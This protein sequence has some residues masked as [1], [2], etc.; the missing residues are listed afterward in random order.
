MVI[1]QIGGNEMKIREIR[2]RK[3]ISRY[4]LAQISDVQDPMSDRRRIECIVR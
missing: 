2:E 3:G 1:N 4:R